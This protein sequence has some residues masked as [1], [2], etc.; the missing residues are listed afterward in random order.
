LAVRAVDGSR[1]EDEKED[2]D[3]EEEED[4]DDEDDD[5][6]DDDDDGNDDDDNEAGTRLRAPV[7]R[8]SPKRR[9]RRCSVAPTGSSA[10]GR[11]AVSKQ[12]L[13]DD[14]LGLGPAAA[15]VVGSI[16]SLAMPFALKAT[17]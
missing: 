14:A 13:D 3:D 9:P 11:L 16:V 4:D 1:D 10:D 6:D 2:D 12:P 8:A 5:D 17:N 15:V 7:G